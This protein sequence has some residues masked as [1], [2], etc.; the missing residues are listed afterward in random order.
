M[1]V[2]ELL[3]YKTAETVET[4]NGNQRYRRPRPNVPRIPRQEFIKWFKKNYHVSQ[5]VTFL[6][7]PGRGKTK[8]ATQLLKVVIS[9]D[10]KV[11][12]LH[13][14]VNGRDTVITATAKEL[15]LKI[16]H[17][18]PPTYDYR[19]RKRNGWILIP[20]EGP[21]ESTREENLLL[22][23]H[24]SRAIHDNYQTR[25][26]KPRI[27]FIDESHQAQEDLKLK[28]N[29]EAPMMRGRPD[30]AV[31]NLIQRGRYVSYHCYEVEHLFIFYDSDSSNTQRYAEMGDCD[32]VYIREITET[33]LK[34]KELPSGDVISDCLYLN[35]TGYMAIVEMD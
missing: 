33:Q 24:F 6:G 2:A 1:V 26:T 18:W 19:D 29:I 8:L 32:P 16:I 25:K 21:G 13:G 17:T 14:K 12:I 20:L 3:N 27:T 22:A 15:N 23:D 9:P 5:R 4:T 11:V 10:R 35:R 31:W 34:R 28:S 30:N 7:P